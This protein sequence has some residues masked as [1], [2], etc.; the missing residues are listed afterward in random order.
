MSTRS[1]VSWTASTRRDQVRMRPIQPAGARPARGG[2]AFGSVDGVTDTAAHDRTAL[3]PPRPGATASR[4]TPAPRARAGVLDTWY[5]SPRLGAPDG[6]PRRRAEL[7][8]LEGVDEVRGVRRLVVRT[9]VEDLQAPPADTPDA[10]LRLHLL[11]HRL[12]A[13]HAST[14]TASSACSPTWCG[15]APARARSTGFESTRL[16][17]HRGARPRHRAR[18][19]QVPADDRLRRARPASGSPTPTGSASAPTS[20]RAPP[21]CTRAS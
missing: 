21:S 18:R 4:R 10:W 19:R 13:P 6:D 1:S 2:T 11:S 17:L 5:P 20:P 16:R 8:R 12:V 9:V 14:S 15:P 7:A 3:R